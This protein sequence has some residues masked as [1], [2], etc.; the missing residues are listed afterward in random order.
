[1]SFAFVLTA[2]LACARAPG[3]A[4]PQR[5]AALVTY[6][7]EGQALEPAL[8]GALS[9]L[10]SIK[11]KDARSTAAELTTAAELGAVCAPNDSECQAKLAVLMHVSLLVVAAAEPSAEGAA[12]DVTVVDA[13]LGRAI[14]HEALVVQRGGERSEILRET[15]ELLLEP[16]LHFG[17]LVIDGAAAGAQLAV[18]GQPFAP[19]P[20][21]DHPLRLRAGAHHL[22]LQPPAGAPNAPNAEDVA[23]LAGQR[24]TVSMAPAHAAAAV[25]SG[26]S[27]PAL[28]AIGALGVAAVGG[29]VALAISAGLGAGLGAAD[30]KV[31][32]QGL[33]VASLMVGGLAAVVAVAAGAVAL[34][35]APADP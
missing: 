13:S 31:G 26:P 16:E 18:D 23:I 2:A 11:L 28:V 7:A 8:R 33:G 29:G 21:A 30:E 34:L 12:L 24:T 6:G 9:S 14:G 32:Y 3:A 25:Q 22:V 5:T 10:A 19:V 1:V 27:V 17:T 35:G 20:G 4:P 15:F